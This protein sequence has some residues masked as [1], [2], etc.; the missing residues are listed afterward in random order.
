MSNYQSWGQYPSSNPH[1][2]FPIFWTSD[3][4]PFETS[5]KPFL[6][7]AHGRSYGDSCL[8]DQGNLLDVSPLRRLIAFDEKTG[9]LRCEAG[10]TFS[11]IHQLT[12]P[13]GWFLP[14]TPGTQFVSI[15]GAIA[16][17]IHGKNHHQAGTF[18]LHVKSFELL[19]S[20][21]EHLLCSPEHN[22]DFY[23]A[24][25]GGLGLTGLILWAEIQLKPV[26]GPWIKTQ[27]LRFKNLKEFFQ[28]STEA[29]QHFEYTVAWID[30]FAKGPHLGRGIFIQGNHQ[31]KE[32]SIDSQF[33][34]RQTR[35]IPLNPPFGLI[36]STTLKWFNSFYYNTACPKSSSRNF[37]PYDRFFYPLDAIRN[38]NRLYGTEGFLQYQCVIPV[39][40]Q[41]EG[42]E[43]LLS[44]IQRSNQGS[45]LAVLK[46]FG[47]I[48]SPGLLSFPKAGTTLALDFPF[49]G[50]KTLKLLSELDEIVAK[51]GGAVYPAKDARMS[52]KH[53]QQYFPKWREFSRFIDPKFSSSFWR[54]VMSDTEEVPGETRHNQEISNPPIFDRETPMSSLANSR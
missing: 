27:R 42:T 52:S 49:R 12:I 51:S 13:T 21:G 39:A 33:H 48:T 19:R 44:H 14:V 9:V 11:D 36:N 25:I 47:T 53:F 2:V 29:D 35:S 16:N 22:L 32:D 41:K 38:A 24:T 18:G 45:S 30:C 4:V 26:L 10:V 23:C 20:N 54:R 15:G 37:E 34:L 5:D 8:N 1:S 31:K 7:Y 43:T 46:Q 50:E 3:T 40:V 6:P 17:D 28:L